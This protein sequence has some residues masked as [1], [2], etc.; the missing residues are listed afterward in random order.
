MRCK[1]VD[2]G[3]KRIS[4]LNAWLCEKLEKLQGTGLIKHEATNG[5]IATVYN[6]TNSGVQLSMTP[7]PPSPHSPT[8]HP[9]KL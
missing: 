1:N 8:P 5:M 6:S 9:K 4:K 3:L 7:F 2:S